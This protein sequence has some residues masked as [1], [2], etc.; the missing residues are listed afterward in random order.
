MIG[1]PEPMC[2][3]GFMVLADNRSFGNPAAAIKD[4]LRD[5][6]APANV[7]LGQHDRVA[8]VRM[9]MHPHVRE[10]ERALEIGS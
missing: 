5:T 8:N 1:Y 2:P 3:I 4:R 7:D 6:A 9:R 10:K